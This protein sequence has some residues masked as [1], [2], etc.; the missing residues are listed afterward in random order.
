[1]KQV[2]IHKLQIKLIKPL[3]LNVFYKFT[4]YVLANSLD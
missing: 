1:M 4:N 3:T 2:G